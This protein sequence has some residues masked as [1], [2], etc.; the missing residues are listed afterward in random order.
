MKQTKIVAT[1]GPASEAKDTLRKMIEAGMNV[2]RLNFSHG[3]HA[4]HK[5]V[6]NRVRELSE[7]LH[8]PIGILA[9]LQGPR[10]RTEVEETIEVK[11]GTRIRVSDISHRS[12][13]LLPASPTPHSRRLESSPQAR[14][15]GALAR[16]AGEQGG[17]DKTIFLDMAGVI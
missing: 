8:T 17:D 16:R 10:I 7:E 13:L 1:I 14:F 3:E 15:A 4:W 2:V 6:I 11:K 5:S 12:D 9:D